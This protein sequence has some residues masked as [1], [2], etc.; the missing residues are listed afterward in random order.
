IDIEN[1]YWYLIKID[2]ECSNNNYSGLEKNQYKITING[3][4]Y[5]IF[6]FENEISCIRNI[7]LYTSKSDS[8]WNVYIAEFNLNWDS[9]FNLEHF[10]FKYTKVIDY[11]RI[12][13][14][15]YF[16][17]SKETTSYREKAEE[18][19]DIENELIPCF[20]KNK[21]FEYENLIVYGSN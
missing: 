10:L 12:N 11:L 18:Y 19:I 8:N 20:Y 1:D 3:N 5:G 6:E 2:F 14:I 9:D 17:F 16:I 15:A 4:D 21:L 13:N 7:N